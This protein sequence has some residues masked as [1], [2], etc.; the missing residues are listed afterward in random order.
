MAALGTAATASERYR[1]TATM[2]TRQEVPRPNATRGTGRF[3]ATQ[4]GRT[5]K[6]KLTFSGLTG[7]ALAAHIHI[8]A[9]GKANPKPAVGLCGPCRSGQRGTVHIS[10]A[11]ERAMERGRAYVNVHTKNN[12]GGEIRGQIVSREIESD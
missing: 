12:P 9:R 5:L 8:A 11:V 2:N 3:T 10:N 6:W 7:K 4:N 1:I